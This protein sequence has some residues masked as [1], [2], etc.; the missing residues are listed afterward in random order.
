[1]GISIG[2]SRRTVFQARLVGHLVLAGAGLLGSAFSLQCSLA[3]A[4]SLAMDPQRQLLALFVALCSLALLFLIGLWSWG[5]LVVGATE[6]GVRRN[7]SA[8]AQELE[9]RMP[10]LLRRTAAGALGASVV[11]SGTA[12]WAAPAPMGA[13]QSSA[14][15]HAA[16]PESSSTPLFSGPSARQPSAPT[17]SASTATASISPLFRT[18]APGP[19][20]APTQKPLTVS[21]ATSAGALVAATP[22]VQD[23]TDPS[24]PA[25]DSAA[26]DPR[27]LL[28]PFFGTEHPASA[29]P[30][31]EGR[32]S[33]HVVLRGE[34]LWS[35]AARTLPSSA[36]EASIQR[37]VQQMAQLNHDVL[38]D[39]PNVILPGTT[40]LL[41]SSEAGHTASP[42]D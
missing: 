24:R 9:H 36:P 21:A 13:S 6:L 10:A 5:L 1:M 38:G 39:D 26:Q 20:S 28:S 18:S 27:G 40:L 34:S 33:T 37:R 14:A 25:P 15:F 7:W 31:E 19:A 11:I 3:R 2:P 32:T 12:A 42:G 29:A 23:S 35:I 17:A 22:A 16:S 30:E 4:F 8:R 41:P